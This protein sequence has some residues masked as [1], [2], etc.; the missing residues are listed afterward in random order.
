MTPV[1][2]LQNFVLFFRRR[3]PRGLR[4][5]LPRVI[6]VIPVSSL[7][8][9]VLNRD[10]RGRA[11]AANVLSFRYGKEY[12]E[13]IIC[14]DVIR[15]EARAAGRDT[16]F[17]T[18]RMVLHAMVHLSGIH[19]EESRG[20]DRKTIQLETDLIGEFQKSGFGRARRNGRRTPAGKKK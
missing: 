14:L 5:G 3:F 7:R 6:R 11:K 1:R 19:H 12:G 18:A 10:Y 4:V 8:S 2:S 15:R 17:Q 13:I 20:A 16:R 9:R